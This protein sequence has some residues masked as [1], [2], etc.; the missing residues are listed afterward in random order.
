MVTITLA[1]GAAD[2][3]ENSFDSLVGPGT[4]LVK[5]TKWKAD[6]EGK[7]KTSLKCQHNSG[8]GQTPVVA[9]RH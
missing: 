8:I 5:P 6:E 7:T 9:C 4:P 2:V 1:R 3:D